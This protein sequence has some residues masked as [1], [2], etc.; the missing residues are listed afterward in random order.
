MD[1][2]ISVEITQKKNL[3]DEH[4]FLKYNAT[5]RNQDKYVHGFFFKFFD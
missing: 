3:N 1:N 4:F 2:D 5:I